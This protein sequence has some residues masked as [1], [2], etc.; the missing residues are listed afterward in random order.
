MNLKAISKQIDAVLKTD[1]DLE[2]KSNL[3]LGRKGIITAALRS[4]KTLPKTER[5]HT[6][7]AL[8]S[9]KETLI[10]KL[11]P[12]AVTEKSFDL[13]L[14]PITPKTGSY[15]PISITINRIVEIFASIGFVT[16]TGNEIVTDYDNFGSLH[17]PLNHPARDTQDSFL[18]TDLPDMLLRTQTSAA[19][20]PIMSSNELPLRVL[21]PGK[22]FRRE[23]DATHQPTF[24]QVEGFIVDEQV[25][26]AD[27]KGMLQYFV[28]E[29][30]GQPMQTRFRPHFF[31]FTEPSAEMDVLWKQPNGSTRWLEIVGSGCIH[32][33]VLQNAGINPKKYQGVA[34]GFG[35]DRLPMLRHGITHMRALSHNDEELLS[36]FAIL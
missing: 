29:F 2:T 26:F 6:G 22:T 7:A 11:Q 9:L 17:F 24:H 3:I 16:L 31:P 14:P 33:A 28:E 12:A 10:K 5:A 19:Q 35:V 23:I 25:T 1:V 15:H 13:S 36:Q 8:N 34:F 18:L 27:L 30:F 20:V 32:P 21:V 4:V